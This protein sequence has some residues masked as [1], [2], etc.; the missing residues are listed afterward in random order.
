IQNVTP[1]VA[2]ALGLEDST[3]ALVTEVPDGPAKE[4]GVI[5]GDVILNFGGQDVEDT[6]AL[7]RMVGDSDVGATVRV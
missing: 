4:A 6:R 2:E 5:A 1:D 3:G 7:V